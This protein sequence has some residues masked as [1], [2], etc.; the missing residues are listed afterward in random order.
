MAT[1]SA[2]TLNILA[3]QL[4]A[5][6][7]QIEQLKSAPPAA[8]P[9]P[10]RA[11]VNSTAA[12]RIRQYVLQHTFATMPELQKA[13]GLQKSAVH[14]YT[15]QLSNNAAVRLVYEPHEASHSSVKVAC[16]MDY[17][18]RELGEA[19]AARREQRSTGTE[20]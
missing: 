11:P 4:K 9:T 10:K 5:L 17:D 8:E 19:L 16:R 18:V 15:Q 2:E 6:S 20:G 3:E 1:Q 7:A 14:Y 12:E 13:L